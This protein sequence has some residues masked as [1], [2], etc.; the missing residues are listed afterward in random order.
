MND[1]DL[2]P[3]ILRGARDKKAWTYF[4]KEVDLVF[5]LETVFY[6]HYYYYY[7]YLSRRGAGPGVSEEGPG[8]QGLGSV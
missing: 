4:I 7:Y 2:S 6:C 5:G 3:C 1:Q 8:F